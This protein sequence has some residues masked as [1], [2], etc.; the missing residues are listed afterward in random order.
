MTNGNCYVPFELIYYWWSVYYLILDE[1]VDTAQKMCTEFKQVIPTQQENKIAANF[2]LNATI[3][4]LV[5]FKISHVN[6][7]VIN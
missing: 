4:F 1:Q 6:L 3:Y 5:D 2:I 7:K